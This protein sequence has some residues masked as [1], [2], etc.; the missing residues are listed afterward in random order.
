MDTAQQHVQGAST[1]CPRCERGNVPAARF[2]RDCGAPLR[3]RCTRCGARSSV[4][5]RYCTECGVVQQAPGA[6]PPATE[7][8][9]RRHLSV[10]F[11]DVADS[12]PISER[13]DPED[14]RE[15]LRVFQRVVGEAVRS[16][17]GTIAQ[18][19]GDGVVAY[20]GMPSAHED[21]A[22]RAV[23]AGLEILARLEQANP[24]L[25]RDYGLQLS[26]RVGVHS[27]LVVLG[28]IG[29]P[30]RPAH[31]AIGDT[32]HLAARL[33]GQA[34]PGRLI[35]TDAT[36]R[37]IAGAFVTE[38]VG[39]LSLR[40]F[41]HPV[42]A[43]RV[44]AVRD[45]VRRLGLRTRARLTPFIDRDAELGM[46]AARWADAR[47]GRGQ[48]VLLDGEPGIGKSR[49]VQ[50]FR[51]SLAAEPHLCF[52][53]DC[54]P[55]LRTSPLHPILD[56]LARA[57]ALPARGTASE[58]IAHLETMLGPFLTHTPDAIALLASLLG[59]DGG[60]RYALPAMTPQRQRRQTLEVLLTLMFETARLQP[61]PPAVAHP[62]GPVTDGAFVALAGRLADLGADV[63]L[64]THD[65][66]VRR[67]A[68]E[69]GGAARLEL[70][71]GVRDEDARAL[72]REGRDVRLYV[73]FG[74]RWLRYWA[75]RIAESRGA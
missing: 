2:C 64:A 72:A 28:E 9:E 71:L 65:P 24:I 34:T 67:W 25:Q 68:L 43:H 18:Y 37:L 58:K 69:A 7:Q 57:V 15:V 22:C 30:T 29:D 36:C 47:A 59:L 21:A 33:C 26:V 60:E 73:P 63:A 54:S 42:D 14:F 39:S 6:P 23:R 48:V 27:G 19:I 32:M 35:V 38:A 5:A 41:S 49:L 12:T 61:G 66:D 11:C 52:E 45:D 13:L 56:V 10:L 16:H 75:R 31:G 3:K 4:A 53:T 51:D 74:P 40:G 46:L 17:D 62:W 44:T 1:A 20:F 55:Y 8:G 50:A 70:L